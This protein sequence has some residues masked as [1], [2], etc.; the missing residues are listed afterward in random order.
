MDS[1]PPR[2]APA[3]LY[4]PPC[5]QGQV[6]DRDETCIRHVLCVRPCPKSFPRMSPQLCCSFHQPFRLLSRLSKLRLREIMKLVQGTRCSR[7]SLGLQSQHLSPW[8]TGLSAVSTARP[9]SC[10]QGRHLPP[11][12]LS[13]LPSPAR[14]C[15]LSTPLCSHHPSTLPCPEPWLRLCH[16]AKASPGVSPQPGRP[17]LS[18]A[19]LATHTCMELSLTASFS[20][21]IRP[22]PAL[23]TPLPPEGTPVSSMPISVPAPDKEQGHLGGTHTGYA[24]EGH[25]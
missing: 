15:P 9:P 2:A 4:S 14:L 23:P 12:L 1:V 16:V 21:C 17:F 18:L 25:D 3:F 6:Q 11:T 22:L 8:H 10:S 7:E 24:L 13:S 19:G 20:L 5:P